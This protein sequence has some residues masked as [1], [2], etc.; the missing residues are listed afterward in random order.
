MITLGKWLAKQRWPAYTG[1]P[2]AKWLLNRGGLLI[3]VTQRPTKWDF[4]I[5]P[6]LVDTY[7]G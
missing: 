4:G 6:T 2:K 7:T 1:Y 5:C 3:Q